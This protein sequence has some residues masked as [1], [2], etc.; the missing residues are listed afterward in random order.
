MATDHSSISI[1]L[2]ELLGDQCST[3]NITDTAH[4][5]TPF[6]R[7]LDVLVN[8]QLKGGVWSSKAREYFIKHHHHHGQHHHHDFDWPEGV[9][10]HG[11][12]AGDG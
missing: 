7:I 11:A 12:A 4:Q 6:N 3:A 10:W 8:P 5:N 2:N 1:E 9:E